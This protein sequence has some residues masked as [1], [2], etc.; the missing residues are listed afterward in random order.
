MTRKDFR[1]LADHMAATRSMF[2]NNDAFAAAVG[3]L[4]TG[5]AFTNG[6]F[7]RRR[8]MDACYADEPT[9]SDD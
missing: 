1:L 5:L 2:V 7:D 4:A 8:F 9:A 6:N 3:M